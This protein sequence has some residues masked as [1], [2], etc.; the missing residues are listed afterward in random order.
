MTYAALVSA[1]PGVTVSVRVRSGDE[2]EGAGPADRLGAAVNPELLIDAVGSVFCRRTG[3]PQLVGD[4]RERR[5]RGQVAQD[6]RLSHGDRR[7]SG[8]GGGFLESLRGSV[9]R[10]RHLHR[11]L[12]YRFRNCSV[13][14]GDDQPGSAYRLDGLMGGC[15]LHYAGA[16]RGAAGV[17]GRGVTNR[18]EGGDLLGGLGLRGHGL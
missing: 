16:N 5:L 17:G 14:G 18:F 8:S 3:D 1:T 10:C 9:A 12:R 6:S 4:Y 15:L 7:S 13:R 11:V 2:P